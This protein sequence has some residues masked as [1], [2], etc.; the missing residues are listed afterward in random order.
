MN[1]CHMLYIVKACEL[2]SCLMLTTTLQD[3][4][5]SQLKDMKNTQSFIQGYTPVNSGLNFNPNL[6]SM[7][8]H[9]SHF[10]TLFTFS[11]YMQS[12]S[13]SF[14]ICLKEKKIHQYLSHKTVTRENQRINVEVLL[15]S[16]CTIQMLDI[17]YI[18]L[19]QSSSPG[20]TITF[21]T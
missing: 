7:L 4:I 6:E 17:I 1:T 8:N 20:F 13:L 3:I 18:L 21:S 10:W 2:L 5:F 12:L 19:R 16:Y 11:N 9:T 14:C 15:K